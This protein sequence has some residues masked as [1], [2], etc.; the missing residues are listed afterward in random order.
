MS[1]SDVIVEALGLIPMRG[2]DDLAPRSAQGP[3]KASGFY[4]WWQTPAAL[5]AVPG[6]PH[7]S[8]DL[9]LELLYVGVAPRDARS[10]SDLRKRLANH[11]RA[12]VGSSTFRLDLAA[13]LWEPMGWTPF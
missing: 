7:P 4:A 2:Y 8:E 9:D 3:P 5:P 10:K 11:H 13:F 12:A 6:E 1:E